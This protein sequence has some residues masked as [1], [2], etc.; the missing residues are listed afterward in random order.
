MDTEKNRTDTVSDVGTTTLSRA[1]VYAPLQLFNCESSTTSATAAAATVQ[2]HENSKSLSLLLSFYSNMSSEF[3]RKA[4]RLD[5]KNTSA[6]PLGMNDISTRLSQ[7]AITF[8]AKYNNNKS[9]HENSCKKK[10]K[11]IKKKKRTSDQITATVSP[12]FNISTSQRKRKRQN[13]IQRINLKVNN[14]DEDFDDS[15]MRVDVQFLLQLNREWNM[16]IHNLLQLDRDHILNEDTTTG[17]WNRDHQHTGSPNIINNNKRL[18]NVHERITALQQN[19]CIEWVGAYVRIS[20]CDAHNNSINDLT[21][22]TDTTQ[23]MQQHHEKTEPQGKQ[24]STNATS[25]TTET[26]EGILISHSPNDWWIIPIIAVEAG[27]CTTNRNKNSN[28]VTSEVGDDGIQPGDT[29]STNRQVTNNIS[30]LPKVRI[31]KQ[32]T[33]KDESSFVITA[34]IPLDN[35]DNNPYSFMVDD[36]R[37]FINIHLQ[38]Q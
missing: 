23:V 30:L 2:S 27:G 21:V 31:P 38:S 19:N 9:Y 36:Q 11:K 17:K 7:R 28:R 22:K 33:T 3:H 25:T 4:P 16:Y 37:R 1:A 10:K 13:L 14:Y 18:R 24:T 12:S 34:R 20:H 15:M 8:T 26:I 32:S 29:A 5:G 6:R 35:N